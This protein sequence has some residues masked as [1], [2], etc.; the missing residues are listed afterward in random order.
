[1]QPDDKSVGSDSK[2]ALRRCWAALSRKDSGVRITHPRSSRSSNSSACFS[3]TFRLSAAAN[4]GSASSTS[5]GVALVESLKKPPVDQQRLF[6][7][8][9]IPPKERS[10]VVQ[11]ARQ[12]LLAN[13][14]LS[15]QALEANVEVELDGKFRSDLSVRVALRYLGNS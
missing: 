7:K 8:Y 14:T 15:P 6:T 1:M 2:S 10:L 5:D 3:F 13:P 9:S 4:P 11:L 12:Q